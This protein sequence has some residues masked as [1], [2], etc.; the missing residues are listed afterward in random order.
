MLCF[1]SIVDDAQI[2]TF[3]III[4]SV[5]YLDSS[6][7]AWRLVTILWFAVTYSRLPSIQLSQ[8]GHARMVMIESQM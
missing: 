3:D 8:A 2:E 7:E 1:V 6:D 5:A 4:S